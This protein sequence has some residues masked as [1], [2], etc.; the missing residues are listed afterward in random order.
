MSYLSGRPTDEELEE[1]VITYSDRL[2]RLSLSM[3]GNAAD[4]EDAVSE[5]M[6]K[7]MLK[8]PEFQDEEHRKA[9]LLRT[10]TNQ[11]RDML[12]HR[13]RR[14]HVPLEEVAEEVA[15]PGDRLFLEILQQLPYKYRAVMLLVYGEGYTSS[16]AAE[17]LHI[18]PAAVRKRLQTGREK[19]KLAMKEEGTDD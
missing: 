7:Y 2:Y 1:L 4:A 5:V 9:W 8:S 11:C 15:D 19:L 18:S 10:T 12:R 6:L 14:R 13:N 16:E 3:L 17:I